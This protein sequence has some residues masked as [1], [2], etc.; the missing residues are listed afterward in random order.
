MPNPLKQNVLAVPSVLPKELDLHKY[1]DYDEQFERS[2]I[3]PISTIL[4][5]IGWKADNRS[6]LEGF[7]I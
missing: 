2:F 1:I 5:A 6:T 7:F 4:T 3:K